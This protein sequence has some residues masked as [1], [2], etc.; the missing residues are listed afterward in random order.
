MP[1]RQKTEKKINKEDVMFTTMV[2]DSAFITMA[3]DAH[4]YK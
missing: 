2:S 3:I 4:K 1:I